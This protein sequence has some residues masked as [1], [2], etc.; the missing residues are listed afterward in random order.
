MTMVAR[1][2]VA[3]SVC[4]HCE[5][6]SVVT[7]T[8]S[9]GASNLDTRPKWMAGVSW[10]VDQC[11]R[12]GHAARDLAAPCEQV[13]Q[14]RAI[15]VSEAYQA[16]RHRTDLPEAARRML[17]YAHL[18]EALGDTVAAAWGCMWS[19]WCCDDTR[20][21]PAGAASSREL[22]LQ[23]FERARELGRPFVD[24]DAPA[25]RTDDDPL[26]PKPA[27]RGPVA[28][29]A[30]I[31]ADVNRRLGRFATALEHCTE[32]L[33]ASPPDD[34]RPLLEYERALAT[35]ADTGAYD[36]SQALERVSPRVVRWGSAVL[37]WGCLVHFV[38]VI[39]GVVALLRDVE[40]GAL[41]VLGGIAS[42]V[43]S[44]LV[45]TMLSWRWNAAFRR[46][47]DALDEVR[48]ARAIEGP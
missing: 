16:I 33:R 38:V 3:C 13:E 30:L 15:L 5:V 2:A 19:A 40:L 44:R 23:H 26:A 17:C 35:R 20:R 21:S 27:P 37:G 46:E 31:L 7:S 24:A 8:S 4:G 43:I 39:A 42:L 41:F 14:V 34:L 29:E 6:R 22:A 18:M 47:M 48:P 10:F 45:W 25:P 11:S 32:G 36:A 12:C 9:F 1:E 28:R